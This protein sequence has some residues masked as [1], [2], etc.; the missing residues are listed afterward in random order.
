MTRPLDF[1]HDS[2]R[3]TQTLTRLPWLLYRLWRWNGLRGGWLPRHLRDHRPFDRGL[4]PEDRPID[5]MVL[6]SDHFEPARR[7]GDVAAAESVRSWC[8][9]YEALASQHR[10][11]DG[12]HPQH[13]WFHRFDYPNPACVRALSDSAFRGFGEVEFHLHHG[14]DTPH[15]F[16]ARLE[17]GLGWFN[18]FG[19]M[20]TAAERPEQRFAYVA[21]N[22][23]LDNGAGDD[24]LSGCDTEL[25]ILREAGCFAD[26]TFPA[27]GEP[28][29]PRQTNSIYYATEDGRPKSYD[30]GVPV[31]VGKPPSGDLMIFQ[32]PTVIDW[33]AGYVEDGVLENTSP[34]DPARM[35]AWL[36]GHVHVLGRPEWVFVKLSTHAMQNR[37]SF[38]SESTE[39]LFEAMEG[40][41][42][43]PPFRLH[44][45]TC[46]EAYN[47]AK[48]AEAGHKGNPNDY[49]D[50]AVPQPANRLVR[51]DADWR[52]LSRTPERLH[53]AVLEERPVQ[54]ELAE[55]PVQFVSGKLREVE[56]RH[57]RGE[58]AAL[59]LEGEGPFEVR[60]RDGTPLV[61]AGGPWWRPLEGAGAH[62][63]HGAGWGGEPL[64]QYS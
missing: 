22:S 13:T 49:R 50:F 62:P 8:R 19:A 44:Y 28:A 14:Y 10:D 47:I 43:R 33:G 6:F 11:S 17:S 18:R 5:V 63:G 46:R 52:L 53:L 7:H 29:Q 36:R 15:S 34:A 60:Q 42:N 48:A 16:A 40:L 4:C 2:P 64:R 41:W 1:A 32:G 30:T 27:I 58:L 24:A 61:P 38:L 25:S 9:D 20:L 54:L 51:C 12:R 21:G 26:F 56:I 39:K 57:A 23:A 31:E 55:T 3:L 37:A 45:V 35:P 59:R